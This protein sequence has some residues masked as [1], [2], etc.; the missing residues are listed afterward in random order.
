MVDGFASDMISVNRGK[1]SGMDPEKDRQRF[2]QYFDAVSF[3]KWDDIN[4]PVIRFSED[5]SLAYMIID[6]IVVL[7]TRDTLANKV[8]ETTHFAW[9][10]IFRKQKD[11]EWKLECVASTNE[12]SI[13]K[14]L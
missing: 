7:D 5:H 4:A 3:K 13:E 14:P 6:K 10:S 8:E 2:Q 11:G 12:P 1:I 9:V